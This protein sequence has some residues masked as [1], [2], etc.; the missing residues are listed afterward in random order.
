V[1]WKLP[2]LHMKRTYTFPIKIVGVGGEGY[3]YCALRLRHWRSVTRRIRSISVPVWWLGPNPVPP[4]RRDPDMPF[5][6]SG[7][8]G[9]ALVGAVVLLC[10]GSFPCRIWRSAYSEPS[11]WG[12]VPLGPKWTHARTRLIGRK[13]LHGAGTIVRLTFTELVEMFFDFMQLEF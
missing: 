8:G 4:R 1:K 10:H 3:C 12:M 11:A 6:V 9:G 5:V 7:T 13:H 2:F